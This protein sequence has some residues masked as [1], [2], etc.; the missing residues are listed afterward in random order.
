MRWNVLIL[1]WCGLLLGSCLDVAEN[2]YELD[3]AV[4]QAQGFGHNVRV[5]Q[6]HAVV[7]SLGP[8][9]VEFWG[10]APGWQGRL[11][12]GAQGGR[13]MDAA[14]TKHHGTRRAGNESGGPRASGSGRAPKTFAHRGRMGSGASGEHRLH[15][16]PRHPRPG[17]RPD[18]WNFAIY[19][20]V[21]DK[22][23][24]VQDIYSVMAKDPSLEFAL[25]S[26]DLTEQGTEEEFQA[27]QREMRTLPFPCFPTLG[28]HDIAT[29]ETLFHQY[30][31]R[32][33]T[34]FSYKG[35]HVTLLDSGNAVIAAPVYDWIDQWMAQ[36][37]DAAHVVVMHIPPLDVNGYRNGAFA[38]RAEAYKL[39]D[40]LNKGRVDLTVYGHVHTYAAFSNAGIPAIISGGGGAIPM[41]FD[42]IG[43]HYLRILAEPE[44][45]AL[46]SSL[47][48]ID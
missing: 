39:L 23:D 22:L 13:S 2:R 5:D 45:G 28:N 21:Q 16:H 29:S 37:K 18:P 40:R 7:R 38:N 42:G 36:G 14:A 35:V 47:I 48:R 9:S 27:F 24:Q 44:S 11:E 6:G 43:R 19:A 17:R 34:H 12:T 4:G 15:L 41:R 10:Q 33:N 25:I 31:G 3:K 46:T 32:G 20:D 8:Q 30:F 26:G 1:A